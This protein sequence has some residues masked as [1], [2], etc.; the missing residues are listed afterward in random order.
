MTQMEHKVVRPPSDPAL[1][2]TA[3]VGKEGGVERGEL[4]AHR[5]AT[6]QGPDKSSSEQRRENS[7]SDASNESPQREAPRTE[8]ARGETVRQVVQELTGVGNGFRDAANRPSTS[9]S[10][11]VAS[12]AAPSSAEQAAQ[13]T[14]A[15]V[16]AQGR[17]LPRDAAAAASPA[18]MPSRESFVSRDGRVQALAPTAGIA[19]SLG[20]G[21]ESRAA[22][23]DLTAATGRAP[24]TALELRGPGAAAGPTAAT[25]AAGTSSVVQQSAGQVTR[26]AELAAAPQESGAV[27]QREVVQEIANVGSLRVGAA[28]LTDVE[29]QALLTM[30]T[31]R[32]IRDDER[33]QLQMEARE[34]R[35]FEREHSVAETQRESLKSELRDVRSQTRDLRVAPFESTQAERA[36]TSAPERSAKLPTPDGAPLGALR[37]ATE[38]I[39]RSAVETGVAAEL[40]SRVELNSREMRLRSLKPDGEFWQGL[41]DREQSRIDSD[42]RLRQQAELLDRAAGG[43]AERDRAEEKRDRAERASIRDRLWRR[44]GKS[45]APAGAEAS[46]VLRGAERIRAEQRQRQHQVNR[47][48]CVLLGALVAMTLLAAQ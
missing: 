16:D 11:R 30:Q 38:G 46:S 33:V 4:Q 36:P 31:S 3:Q 23:A 32:V 22:Q 17:Q 28:M 37:S 39:H 19:Q 47:I 45:G 10:P 2:P 43:G 18:S 9:E 41:A 27:R 29:R 34:M 44:F 21:L 1:K 25:A 40:L 7:R 5:E 15:G 12:A 42:R 35:R 24:A 6:R 48:F 20:A 13:Q 14:T 8:S 26:S